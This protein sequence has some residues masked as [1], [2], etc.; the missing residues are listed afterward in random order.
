MKLQAR[1]KVSL[2]SWQDTSPTQQQAEL[3]LLQS[4]GDGVAGLVLPL[5]ASSEK[6]CFLLLA[7]Y[8]LLAYFN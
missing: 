1:R 5:Y 6:S 8:L 4:H 3:L 7:L 2:E